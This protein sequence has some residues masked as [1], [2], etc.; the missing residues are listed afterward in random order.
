M[1][2]SSVYPSAAKM[3]FFPSS[4]QEIPVSPFFCLSFSCKNRFFSLLQR[5]HDRDGDTDLCHRETQKQPLCLR[6]VLVRPREYRR[7]NNTMKPEKAASRWN[8]VSLNASKVGKDLS[9][10][11]KA[12]KLAF[13]HWIE[14]LR[15]TM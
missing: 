6:V 8:C 3:D 12:K 9:K 7:E 1:P 10:D 15:D 13:R 5:R 4:T 11:A 14:A 2:L